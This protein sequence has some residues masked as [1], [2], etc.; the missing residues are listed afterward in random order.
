MPGHREK[1]QG[2]FDPRSELHATHKKR[3]GGGQYGFGC[4][5]LYLCRILIPIQKPSQKHQRPNFCRLTF[6]EPIFLCLIQN[7]KAAIA[8]F[9]PNK[10]NPQPGYSALWA[11][12][13]YGIY[14]KQNGSYVAVSEVKR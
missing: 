4:T 10:A 6:Q 3:I 8:L 1:Y 12:V 14:E 2:S 7:P 9:W 13:L 5:A 11:I